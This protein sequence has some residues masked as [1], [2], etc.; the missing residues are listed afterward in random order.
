MVQKYRYKDYRDNL[1][2]VFPGKIEFHASNRGHIRNINFKN[3]QIPDGK[4]PYSIISGFDEDHIVENVTFE[5]ITAQLMKISN[6][7]ELKLFRKFSNE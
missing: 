2:P 7:K 6:E 5:N 3:I 4:F 1:L